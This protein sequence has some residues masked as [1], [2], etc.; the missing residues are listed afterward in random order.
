MKNIIIFGGAFDPIHNGHMNMAIAASKE[1]S[2]DVF[3]VPAKISVWKS[4]SVDVEHKIKMLELAIK[5]FGKEDIFNISRIEADSSE[6]TTY[7]YITV[8]KF[9]ELYP[10]DK[11]FLL[12]GSDQVNNFEKWK[13]AD[14]IAENTQII[15]FV[16]P[17]L[18]L[19]E[20]N[21]KRFKMQRIKGEAVEEASTSIKDF[22]SL[23]TPLSVIK[24][25]VDNNL[26]FINKIKSYLTEKRY[27]HSLSVAYLAYDIAIKNNLKNPGEYFLTSLLHDIGKKMPADEQRA[28]MEKLYPQYVHLPTMIYH[29]FIGAYLAKKEFGMDDEDILDA[30]FSDFCIGK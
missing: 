19:N 28:L 8:R 12:I 25:I 23:N 1:L 20:D 11:L 30:I 18:K 13:N 2:A 17:G 27:L 24:Y 26:Y 22:K 7:S 9:K 21:I 15:Y 14:E 10:N 4:S 3:F 5:D 6:D 29:Q 16:R